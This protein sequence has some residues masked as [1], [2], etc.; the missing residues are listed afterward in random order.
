V[1]FLSLLPQ[2]VPPGADPLTR[3]LLLSLMVVACA[4]LWFPA[5]A[6]VV[7]SIGA[8]LGGIRIQRALTVATSLLLL[9]LSV[10][11]LVV[12]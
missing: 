6:L 1:R 9:G 7:H 4:L 2:F 12:G 5:I 3:S 8:L 11:V 10:R